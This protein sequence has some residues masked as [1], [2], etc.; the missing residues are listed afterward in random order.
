LLGGGMSLEDMVGEVPRALV[1][2]RGWDEIGL[3]VLLKVR[4]AVG[5]KVRQA[6][7]RVS[8]GSSVRVGTCT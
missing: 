8:I 1:Q 4:A 6:I 3:Y 7:T 5:T 2:G